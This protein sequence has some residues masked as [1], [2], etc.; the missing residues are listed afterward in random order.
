MAVEA[1]PAEDFDLDMEQL[2]SVAAG[3]ILFFGGLVR[4]GFLGKLTALGGAALA[5]HGLRTAARYAER[6]GGAVGEDWEH[7]AAGQE[8]RREGYYR[9]VDPDAAEDV[10]REASEESFPASDSPAWTPTTG[11]G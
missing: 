10:V 8:A 5:V 9:R 3:A 1:G 6:P 11:T 7:S 4:G 2:G